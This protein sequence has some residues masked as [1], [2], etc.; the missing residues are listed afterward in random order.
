MRKVFPLVVIGE[1]VEIEIIKKT[2]YKPNTLHMEVAKIIMNIKM[3]S[4][5]IKVP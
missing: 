2:I 3:C 4:T 1:Y 5:R